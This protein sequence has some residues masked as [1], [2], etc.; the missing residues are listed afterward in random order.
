MSTHFSANADPQERPDSL[1]LIAGYV[2]LL[3]VVSLLGAFTLLV[4]ALPMAYSMA[5]NSDIF[6]GGFFIQAALVVVCV[7]YGIWGL[8]CVRG[9][10]RGSRS[11]RASSLLYVAL[12]GSASFIALFVMPATLDA[13]S[14]ELNITMGASASLLVASGLSAFWLGR[15]H[16]K[17]YFTR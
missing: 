1:L 14:L 8:V 6:W 2:M 15:P 9:L 17:A 3:A 13:G 4:T 5:L 16:I 10:W 12:V 7:L 11:M